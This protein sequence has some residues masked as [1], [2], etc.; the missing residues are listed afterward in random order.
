MVACNPCS[1]HSLCLCCCDLSGS[2]GGKLQQPQQAASSFGEVL[3]K[4]TSA[5]KASAAAAIALCQPCFH[6]SRP[7]IQSL[8]LVFIGLEREAAEYVALEYISVFASCHFLSLSGDHAVNATGR[9]GMDEETKTARSRLLVRRSW[10]FLSALM[11]DY[12]PT[13]P[14]LLLTDLGS[15][16]QPRKPEIK[17][18]TK[19]GVF[20]LQVNE[21]TKNTLHLST[22]ST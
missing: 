21:T 9:G 7:T 10:C 17:R 16:L 15:L 22:R 1:S 2:A 18:D 20:C 19:A 13:A 11:R 14:P 5:R 3:E 12:G 6:S 8:G 4:I